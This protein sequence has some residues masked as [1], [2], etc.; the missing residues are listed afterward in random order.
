MMNVRSKEYTKIKGKQPWYCLS[1]DHRC[2]ANI[3]AINVNN[4]LKF[5]QKIGKLSQ[6]NDHQSDLTVARKHMSWRQFCTNITFK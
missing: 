5:S 6:Q 3:R 2:F 4:S 1:S